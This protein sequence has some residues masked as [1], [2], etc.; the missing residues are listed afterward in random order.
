MCS[1][2]L[3]RPEAV[4]AAL[5]RL[6]ADAD[7]FG[8]LAFDAVAE[9]DCVA[10]L[11]RLMT[12]ARKVPAWQYELINQLTERAV[13]SDIGGSLPRVL[14]DRLKM[15]PSSA[16]RLIKEA[17]QLGHRRALSGGAVG[18]AAVEHRSQGARWRGRVRAR[19]G[20]PRLL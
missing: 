13:A 1:N 4:F 6:E 8:Q 3:A 7:A 11:D 16:R 10:I 19:G 18:A 2:G 5:D 17:K 15:R 9:L 14:A 12:V 20:D